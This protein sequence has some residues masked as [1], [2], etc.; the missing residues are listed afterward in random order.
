M[1]KYINT[2]LNSITI[3]KK[4]LLSLASLLAFT[5]HAQNTCQEVIAQLSSTSV[6]PTLISS[7][8][9][10]DICL[11]ETIDFEAMG[12]Y[13]ENN[14]NYL[15]SDATSSFSWSFDDVSIEGSSASHT[16]DT[17]GMHVISLEITDVNSCISNNDIDFVVR[18]A[19]PS[20]IV[21][22]KIDLQICSGEPQLL[23]TTVTP[24]LIAAFPLCESEASELTF[25]PDGTENPPESGNW[26]AY[27]TPVYLN[28]YDSGQT[29]DNLD[30]LLRVCVVME[31]SYIGDLTINLFS[32]SGEQ[33]TL[34]PDLNGPGFGNGIGGGYLGEPDQTDGT[35]LAGVGYTYCWSPNADLGLINDVF[36]GGTLDASD[37]IANTNIYAAHNNSFNNLLGEPMNGLWNIEITDSF[38]SDDGYVFSWWIDFD[39]AITSNETIFTPIEI[40]SAQWAESPI[41][42]SVDANTIEIY[43]DTEGDYELSYTIV[44]AFGCDYTEVINVTVASGIEM[45]NLSIVADTNLLSV[46]S[47]DFDIE[48]G[49]PPYTI[50]WNNDFI[51]TSNASVTSGTYTVT[52]S[53]NGICDNSETYFLD[54]PNYEGLDV[55]EN[56]IEDFIYYVN[57]N[58]L[59]IESSVLAYELNIYD[60]NG[61]HILS[62]TILQQDEIPLQEMSKGIYIMIINSKKGQFSKKIQIQ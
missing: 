22:D 12:I 29:L 10:Y 30:D 23:T 61:R 56:S 14:I 17:P 31:H 20:E 5:S 37:I 48:G 2:T 39:E 57:D 60:I 41:I 43:S 45:T 21:F 24:S 44:D 35:G 40:N 7:D 47:I 36:A 32:P 3:M 52:L 19:E 55:Q 26:S 46:G 62:K 16:F 33:V 11:G 58:M 27:D 42:T 53:D 50:E 34:L 49:I 51:G 38:P 1:Y 6:E 59:H 4:I 28:C 9:Y 15:Q 54:V 18:V 25:L 13:P 8:K